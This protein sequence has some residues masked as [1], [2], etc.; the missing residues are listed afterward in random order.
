MSP[1]SHSSFSTDDG[2]RLHA[3]HWRSDADPAAI[4]LLVHGYA[5]HCGRYDHVAEAFAET[6][7]AVH[8][9][10]QRGHGRSDGPRAY[11]DDFGDYLADLD[12]FRRHVEAQSP[13]RPLFLF[14]HSMG[15]LAVLLY[16][17]DRA[18]DVRGLILS[19]PPIEINPDLAPLLRRMAQFLGR[20]VPTFPTV[21]SPRDAI[22]RDPAVVEAANHDPLSYHGRTKARMGAEMLRAGEEAQ[23]RL[24]E[25]DR[26]FLAIHGTAD[27]LASPAW[28]KR[29]YERAAATDK[30]LRLYDGLYHETFNEPEQDTVLRDL[31]TWLAERMPTPPQ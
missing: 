31:G 24:H 23:A 12:H 6:G 10:D 17:L 11:V 7:A 27:R 4:L 28:S 18:V 30:T 21:R 8:A 15:G 1:S 29:L 26:P 16:V 25:L 5:E 22:S 20:W 9:Y 14:G 13:D 2:L 19:A 3:Q